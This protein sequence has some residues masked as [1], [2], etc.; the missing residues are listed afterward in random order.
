MENVSATVAPSQPASPE[1]KSDANRVGNLSV[2]EAAQSLLNREAARTKAVEGVAAT[3]PE[4]SQPATNDSPTEAAPNAESAAPEAETPAEAPQAEAEQ[5]E[6]EQGDDVHSQSIPDDLKKKIDKRIGKEVAKRK[7][8]EAQLN[9]ISLKLQAQAAQQQQTPAA[10]PAIVPLPAGAPPLANIEDF[11]GLVSLQQQAKEA[12]RWAEEQLDQE[13]FTPVQVNGG[14]LG[15][16]ELKAIVRNAAKTLEDEIPQRAQ[17]LQEKQK[18]QQVAYEQF[19]F[20]K[21]KSS[22][23]YVQ[24]QQAFIAMPWL[25]NLPNADWIVGVQIEGLK[26][27]ESKKRNSERAKSTTKP[28]VSNKPPSSQ[29][30]VSSAGGETRVPTANKSQAQI[31]SMRQQLS[32]S[33]GVTA[34]QAAAFLLQRELA[35]NNR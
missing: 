21:D 9:E 18:A 30:A 26:A 16:Q 6:P 27:L 14:V 22:T 23:E 25:K 31:E 4:Q 17:F 20:L 29:T 2:A 12:K 7:A 34:N 35:K 11:G 19:P 33:G 10:T 32:K 24:A 13:N 28:V 1:V 15:R 8:L 3:P 5:G